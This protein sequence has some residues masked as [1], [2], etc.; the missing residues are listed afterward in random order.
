[1][2]YNPGTWHNCSQEKLTSEES[3]R[4]TSRKTKYKLEIQNLSVNNRDSVTWEQSR[5]SHLETFVPVSLGNNRI[6][7]TWEETCQC[8]MPLIKRNA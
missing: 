1:M 7:L 5:Q 3:C 8:H 2:F 4:R 6:S